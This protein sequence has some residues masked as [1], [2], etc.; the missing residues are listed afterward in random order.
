M[1]L[2]RYTLKVN[3]IN[4][5][6]SLV[7]EVTGLDHPVNT[8][9]NITRNMNHKKP[10]VKTTRDITKVTGLQ[11]VVDFKKDLFNNNNKKL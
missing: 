4:N 11:F 10:M 3:R 7:V 8:M 1:V 6:T 9:K 2:F 5:C